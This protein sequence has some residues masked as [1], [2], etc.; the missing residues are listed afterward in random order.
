MP[1]Y[2]VLMRFTVDGVAHVEAAT[3]SEAEEKSEELTHHETDIDPDSWDP[4]VMDV[5][6]E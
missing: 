5:E 2:K 6:P 4:E 1:P 3:Q